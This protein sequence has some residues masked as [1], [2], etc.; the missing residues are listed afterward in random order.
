MKIKWEVDDGY[1]G[2]RPQYSSVDDEEILECEDV[3]EA[4][5]VV[6]DW[7]YGDY[8]DKIHYTYDYDKIRDEVKKL[9][10]SKEK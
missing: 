6:D 2:D 9:L 5:D 10:N 1:I 4:M 7:I 3:D 8:Q